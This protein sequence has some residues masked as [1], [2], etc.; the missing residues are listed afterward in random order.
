MRRAAMTSPCGPGDWSHLG[1]PTDAVRGLL[2]AY[3]ADAER[4]IAIYAELD[5]ARTARG[6]PVPK[7][8]LAHHP[9]RVPDRLV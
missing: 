3:D 7:N 9:Y 6:E 1:K 8:Q 4:V 5:A 2:R